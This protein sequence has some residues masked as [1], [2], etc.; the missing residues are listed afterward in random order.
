MPTARPELFPDRTYKA[1]NYWVDVLFQSTPPAGDTDPPTP[2]TNLIAIAATASRI[3]LAWGPSSDDT[4]VTGYE[5]ARDGTFLSTTASASFSDTGL[6]PGMTYSYAMRAFDPAGNVSE[7]KTASAVTPD[8][9]PPPACAVA[10]G[11]GADLGSAVPFAAASAWN[12][13]ISDA[14]VAANSAEIIAGSGPSA[15][16]HP[17]FG[18]GFYNGA[19]IGIPYVVVPEGQPL[20]PLELGSYAASSDP[21]PYPIPPEAP[22]EGYGGSGDYYDRHVLVLQ[23]D[24]HAPG[25]LGSLYELFGAYPV[26]DYPNSVDKWRAAQGSIFD[27]AGGDLQRPDGWTSADAAGLPI[28]PGLLRFDEVQRAIARSGEQ[29]VIP[30]ALRFTLAEGYTANAYVPPG[31]HYAGWDNGPA[32]FGMRVRLRSDW[33]PSADFPIEVK[34]IIN[35]LKKYG[36]IMADNGGNWFISGA[37]DERWNNDRLRYL[38]YVTGRDFEVVTP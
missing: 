10:L 2:P 11:I 28:F 14:P 33:Q 22:I 3:D 37:P 17:D 26:G 23:R 30:H 29:G 19:R 13:D 35:T 25:C 7:A 15:G 5:V 38:G 31:Q 16:L 6:S 8:S 34:V 9:A 21:G 18:A 32:P 20:V 24:P 36:M 12:Q 1:T 27:M 4:A